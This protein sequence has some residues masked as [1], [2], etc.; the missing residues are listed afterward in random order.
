M[1]GIFQQARV[2]FETIY[3]CRP[4][5]GLGEPKS[6]CKMRLASDTAET[7]G[8]R[9]ASKRTGLLKKLDSVPADL[10]RKDC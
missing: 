10:S 1:S 5:E 9:D 3:A 2:G 4:F 6:R 7:R 8:C